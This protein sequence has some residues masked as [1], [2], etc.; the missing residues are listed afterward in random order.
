MLDGLRARTACAELCG[1]GRHRAEPVLH[2]VEGVHEGR[3]APWPAIPRVLQPPARSQDLRREA[4][5]LKDAWPIRRSN[6]VC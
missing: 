6:T 4:R 3:Q 1:N 2:L 5:A